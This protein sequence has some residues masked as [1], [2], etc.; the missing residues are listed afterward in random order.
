MYPKVG[1]VEKANRGKN[2]ERKI[3]NNIEIHY[4]CIGIRHNE[5]H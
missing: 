2:K 4:L 3:V 1:V 5:T